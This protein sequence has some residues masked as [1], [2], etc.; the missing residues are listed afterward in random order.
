M[1]AYA[2]VDLDVK[3]PSKLESYRRDVPAT[4]A[5]YGG[6]FIVRGGA[7]E[8]LE[9]DW[10]PKRIVVLEFP[11]MD[12]LKRWYHSE[13][14]KPLLAQRLAHSAADLIAVEGI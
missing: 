8:V 13:E 10:T 5:K 1:V 12:A 6:R 2:I 14:Y 11:T 7:C 9:G 4:V 3:D